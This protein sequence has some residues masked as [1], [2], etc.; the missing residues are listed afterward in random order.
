M[1]CQPHFIEYLD[2]AP[3]LPDQA[4]SLQRFQRDADA[5]PPDSQHGTE[6]GM[7][8]R[9]HRPKLRVQPEQPTSAPRRQRVVGIAGG[10]QCSLHATF[11]K[12][13][14]VGFTQGWPTLQSLL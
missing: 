5:R 11:A 4:T 2:A 14:Q 9:N 1:R 3:A 10:N 13:P 12:L 8:Y 7:R 6:E